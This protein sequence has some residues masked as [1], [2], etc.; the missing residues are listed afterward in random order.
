MRARAV[1]CLALA[2]HD[3]RLDRVVVC[4]LPCHPDFQLV[5]SCRAG[6]WLCGEDGGMECQGATWPSPETCN[7]A[8]DDCDGVID[9][10]DPRFCSTACGSGYEFCG[11]GQWQQ[12]NA[13]QPKPEMCDGRDNDCDGF[14]DEPEE[15]RAPDGGYELGCFTPRPPAQPYYGICHGGT[16]RCIGGQYDCFG[17]R[18]PETEICDGIDD[19]CDGQIDE[20]VGG[21]DLIDF[22][23]IYDNSCSMADK[24][25]ALRDATRTW[26]FKYGSAWRRRY[27]V[28]GAPDIDSSIAYPRIFLDFS[29][30]SSFAIAIAAQDGNTGTGAEPTLDAIA[31]T[32]E[33]Q[34]RPT[35]QSIDGGVGLSWRAGS[36]R[37]VV[38]FSDEEPQS[39]VSGCSG[40]CPPFL[41]TVASRLATDRTTLFVFTITDPTTC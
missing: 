13:P 11:A 20:G 3:G 27:A 35:L 16:W 36:L 12:C 22:V 6:S 38:L 33:D 40:V 41:M 2:C 9:G 19:N 37:V 23:L 10:L 14:I 24:A 29:D 28:I 34:V 32:L 18:L 1:L 17:Q 8:D 26:A 7:L 21:E 4:G 5:G 15:L 30:A 25:I 31:E 39:Y